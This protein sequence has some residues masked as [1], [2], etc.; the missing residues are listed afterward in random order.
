MNIIKKAA[1]AVVAGGLVLTGAAT[2]EAAVFGPGKIT[3]Y[4]K[5]YTPTQYE[6][7]LSNQTANVFVWADTYFV[8]CRSASI[9]DGALINM[10][11]LGMVKS[12]GKYIKIYTST[13]YP[14][15][16]ACQ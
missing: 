8:N 5:H 11:R 12:A 14:T 15:Y 3:A 16:I 1:V 4:Y 9:D 6:I 2:A 13:S 10:T 7:N